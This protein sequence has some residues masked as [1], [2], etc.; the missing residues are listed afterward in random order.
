MLF[1][2]S[3][4]LLVLCAL[5]LWPQRVDYFPRKSS[6]YLFIWSAGSACWPATSC[7]FSCSSLFT[8]LVTFHYTTNCDP[9]TPADASRL[10]PALHCARHGGRGKGAIAVPTADCRLPS[11]EMGMAFVVFE[12]GISAC[13]FYQFASPPSL[14]TSW[15]LP[16]RIRVLDICCFITLVKC[17]QFNAPFL[18]HSPILGPARKRHANEPA[19]LISSFI[20]CLRLPYQLSSR[21][22]MLLHG[23][24]LELPF[25]LFFSAQRQ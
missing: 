17:I 5:V 7:C 24:A 11:A 6:N 12:N 16:I 14:P 8:Q 13:N 18:L 3:H 2:F 20:Y 19:T 10:T 9:P 1:N 22:A 21:P 23:S 25:V 15:S 4:F